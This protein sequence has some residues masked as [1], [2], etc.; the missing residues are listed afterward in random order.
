MGFSANKSKNSSQQQSTSAST[1]FNQAYPFLQ[2]AYAPAT[3]YTGQASNAIAS[4]LGLGGGDSQNAAFQNFKDSS[5]YNFIQNEGVQGIEGSAASKGLLK[6][7]STLKAITGYSSN[8]AKSFL[9]SYL[10]NLGGLSNTGIQA[11]QIIGGAGNQSNSSSSS[12]G[13]SKGSS[14]GLSVTGK[15]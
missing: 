10:S 3:E 7:G 9:D 14:F 4:L 12:S 2:E 8:L 13:T 1:S 6:S 11:G 15:R 5:G